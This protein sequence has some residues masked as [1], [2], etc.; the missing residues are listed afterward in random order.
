M[1]GYWL[2]GLWGEAVTR[3][4]LWSLPPAVAAIFLGRAVNQRIKGRS[5]LRYIHLGLLGI[6]VVLLAQSLRR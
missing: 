2:A 1:V 3:Y 6:G 5:F 4:Y